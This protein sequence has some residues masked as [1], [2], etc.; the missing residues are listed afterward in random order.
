MA[1][2]RGITHFY[3]PILGVFFPINDALYSI[4]FGTH[5]KTAKPIEM[6]F[7]LMTWVC[8]RYCVSDGDPILK[9]K[10]QFSGVGDLNCTGRCNK[11]HSIVNNVM[12]QKGL[13][14]MPGKRK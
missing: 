10:G 2:V 13:F 8:P 7:R 3:L 14:C 12:Q 6:P 1:R 5:T 4:A 11:D 9:G